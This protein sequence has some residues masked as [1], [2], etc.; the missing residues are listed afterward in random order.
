MEN[1][2]RLKAGVIA[3]NLGRS[4]SAV[5]TRANAEHIKLDHRRRWVEW[6]DKYIDRFYLVKTVNEIASDI[7]RSAGS[8]R[9]RLAQL[10]ISFKL[11][12]RVEWEHRLRELH[13]MGLVD[14][15]IAEAM[16]EPRGT[17]HS[18]RV[19]LGLPANGRH[20][21]E[22]I[23]RI[24]AKISEK[25]RK[26]LAEDGVKHLC[27]Y[28]YIK[29]RREALK[30]GWVD[31]HSRAEANVLSLLDEEPRTCL[32]IAEGLQRTI[33]G[34]FK[35]IARLRSRGLIKRVGMLPKAAGRGSMA[36]YGL[37][38]GVYRTCV[39]NANPRT[40]RSYAKKTDKRICQ[41]A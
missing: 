6:E 32:Q 25:M 37:A 38:P 31:C 15:E 39:S 1:A 10:G 12:G 19:A 24:K 16:R 28:R 17:T 20:N 23:R 40:L 30:L 36:L 9:Q 21:E 26:K 7:G 27:E 29:G 3:K 5:Y 18:R 35:L 4:L 33:D 13:A 8:V 11:A 14:R 41:G 34:A 22:C 2:R